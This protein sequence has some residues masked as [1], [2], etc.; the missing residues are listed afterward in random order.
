M[1]PYIGEYVKEVLK[2]SVEPSIQNNL[3]SNLKSF[4][5]ESIDMGDIVSFQ[6]LHE[7]L[8]EFFIWIQIFDSLSELLQTSRAHTLWCFVH[9]NIVFLFKEGLNKSDSTVKLHPI[10]NW[11]LI[12]IKSF[13]IFKYGNEFS[14]FGNQNQYQ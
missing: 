4:K 11:S 3:P 10:K 1:W 6:I 2:V 9:I 12:E 13:D 7:F 8:I 5:F 14:I